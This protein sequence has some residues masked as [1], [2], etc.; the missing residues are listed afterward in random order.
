MCKLHKSLYGLKQAPRTW[1]EKF[2][3]HILTLGFKASSS[4]SSLFISH[5]DSSLTV[6][7]LYVDDITVTG[8]NSSYISSLKYQLSKAFDMKDLGPLHYF[9]GLEITSTATGIFVNQEKYAIDLLKRIDMIEAKSCETPCAANV[10]LSKH[11][12]NL[13]PDPTLYRSIVGALQY[14][15]FSRP[16][17]A[18]AVNHVCQFMHAPTDL[19]LAAVKRILRYLKGTTSHGIHF[20]KGNLDLNAYTDADW[21]G[22]P[23]DRRSTT[24]FIISWVTIQ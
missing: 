7:L 13:R 2:T 14:L 17:L 11:E 20:Q 10:K 18:F 15:T 16:D 8:N 5:E 6:L 3:T 22:D 23:N 1:F 9:L 4:D 12:G 21:A 19:H 24:G